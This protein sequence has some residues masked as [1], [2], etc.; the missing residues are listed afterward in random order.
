MALPP[1][2]RK[3]LR[4]TSTADADLDEII[5]YILK[6]AGDQVAE[7]FADALDVKL[8]KLAAV[9]HSDVSREHVSPGLSMM[10]FKAYCIYF[11]LT[12]TETLLSASCTVPGTSRQSSSAHKVPVTQLVRGRSHFYFHPS[13]VVIQFPCA[14]AMRSRSSACGEAILRDNADHLERRSAPPAHVNES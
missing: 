14:A 13:A 2:G 5:D 10:T 11:R 12:A 6:Q 9:G 4:I 7:A 3:T 8:I 1:I